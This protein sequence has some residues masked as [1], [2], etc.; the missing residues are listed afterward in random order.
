MVAVRKN[1]AQTWP[2]DLPRS[3]VEALVYF[4]PEM[5]RLHLALIKQIE[6]IREARA[7][8]KRRRPRSRSAVP[9]LRMRGRSRRARP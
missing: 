8:A 1:A 4:G 2:T 5:I 7:L 6:M 3:V 9:P